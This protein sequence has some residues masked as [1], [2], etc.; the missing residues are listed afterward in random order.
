M[1]STDLTGSQRFPG[2]NTAG[3]RGLEPCR[4]RDGS[5]AQQWKPEI[6]LERR[7]RVAWSEGP[8]SSW[9]SRT[10]IPDAWHRQSCPLA[11]TYPFPA[12]L[13]LSEPFLLPRAVRNPEEPRVA[14]SDRAAPSMQQAQQSSSS[15]PQQERKQERFP[16]CTASASLSTPSPSPGAGE[17]PLAAAGDGA[18]AVQLWKH[19]ACQC[20]FLQRWSREAEAALGQDG[21]GTDLCSCAAEIPQSKRLLEMEVAGAQRE[22]YKPV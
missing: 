11:Q 19:P 9:C 6:P 1:A 12:V 14:S 15:H 16:S 17:V 5:S 4:G 21:S 13:Q 2:W 7:G 22:D 8:G 18:A 3:K 20:G 10:H